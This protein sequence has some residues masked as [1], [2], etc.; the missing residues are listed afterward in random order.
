MSRLRDLLSRHREAMPY[1][2]RS[3]F[4]QFA[5]R[6]IVVALGLQ[7]AMAAAVLVDVGV[8]RLLGPVLALMWDILKRVAAALVVLVMLVVTAEALA[9][10]R[11]TNGDCY[12][13]CV[14]GST[15]AVCATKFGVGVPTDSLRLGCE[16]FEARTLYENINF[17]NL[18]GP[19]WGPMYD[20][21]ETT[22]PNNRGSNSYWHR[23]YGNGSLGSLIGF[24]QPPSPT[25]GITC[26][27]SPCSGHMFWHPQNLWQH[28]PLSRRE[29]SRSLRRCRRST[30]SNPSRIASSLAMGTASAAAL[31]GAHGAKW[32]S[33]WRS[34]SRPTSS[35]VRFWTG[36]GSSTNGRP[37]AGT[38]DSFCSMAR[39]I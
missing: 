36:S 23:S 29:R 14:R 34:P 12:C 27:Q 35:R 32:V 6:A 17:G 30:A 11:G 16:D 15:N 26:G 5:R 37:A 1:M 8:F 18:S 9:C 38:T 19:D 10:T 3:D 4:E 24:G 13:D 7:G 25:L 28:N 39:I 22:F 31:A 21:S 20:H 2:A 33:R